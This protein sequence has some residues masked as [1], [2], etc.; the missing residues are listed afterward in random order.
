MSTDEHMKNS[1]GFTSDQF[2]SP[3]EL[4]KLTP[5]S[6]PNKELSLP[7]SRKAKIK[8]LKSTIEL[9]RA[10]LELAQNEYVKF[11]ERKDPEPT[12]EEV[13]A[14]ITKLGQKRAILSGLSEEL[15]STVRNRLGSSFFEFTP[16][17]GNRMQKRRMLKFLSKQKKKK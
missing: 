12:K 10:D 7:Y 8:E 1:P 2:L 3:E 15:Q 4:T 6:D 13:D 16:S 5:D 17:P 9:A 14:E 11:R